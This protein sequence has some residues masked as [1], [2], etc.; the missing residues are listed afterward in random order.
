MRIVT[1]DSLEK[2]FLFFTLNEMQKVVSLGGDIDLDEINNVV[3]MWMA[4]FCTDLDIVFVADKD[5][6]AEHF[7]EDA[8]YLMLM[9]MMENPDDE[10]DEEPY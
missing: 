10:P 5:S 1:K 2:V 3:R 4:N 6:E 9:T 8:M 7:A